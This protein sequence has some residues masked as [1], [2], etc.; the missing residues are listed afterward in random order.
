MEVH[1]P[2][3]SSGGGGEQRSYVGINVL[4]FQHKRSDR[5]EPRKKE[6]SIGHL[7][8]RKKSTLLRAGMPRVAIKVPY[9]LISKRE[10]SAFRCTC[11]RGV[12]VCDSSESEDVDE[13]SE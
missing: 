11:T 2:A 10:D 5:A 4:F 3:E 12:R 1:E 7:T 13:E 6:G 8:M 9:W